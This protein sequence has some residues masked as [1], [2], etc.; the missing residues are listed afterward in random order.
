VGLQVSD[1]LDKSTIDLLDMFAGY[2]L[3]GYVREGVSYSSREDE[4]K[5]VARACYDL[6][7]AMLKTRKEILQENVQHTSK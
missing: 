2:A 6:A 7:Y 1:K 3:S 4:C 5:E